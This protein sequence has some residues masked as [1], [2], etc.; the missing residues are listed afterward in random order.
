MTEF[1]QKFVHFKYLIKLQKKK[2]KNPAG[3]LVPECAD[4]NEFFFFT[5]RKSQ[6]AELR[7]FLLSHLKLSFYSFQIPLFH[8]SLILSYAFIWIIQLQW[9]IMFSKIHMIIS[10]FPWNILRLRF[11]TI[12]QSETTKLLENFPV[13]FPAQEIRK[14]SLGKK[15]EYSLYLQKIKET[16]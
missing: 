8:L 10:A 5:K 13:I 3:H 14:L 16:V 4:W 15:Q 7:L 6:N 1:Q 12:L 11:F 2:K 9:K